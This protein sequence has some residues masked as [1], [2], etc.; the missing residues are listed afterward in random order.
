MAASSFAAYASYGT[1]SSVTCTPRCAANV[2]ATVSS[3]FCSA[4]RYG[5][6]TTIPRGGS[7]QP[8]TTPSRPTTT[9]ARSVPSSLRSRWLLVALVIALVISVVIASGRL[10]AASETERHAGRRVE[11]VHAGGGHRELDGA[12][13]THRAS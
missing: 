3:A 13:G 7:L 11:E 6:H 8:E 12:A 4:P 2:C 10:V 5:C 9:R 1:A